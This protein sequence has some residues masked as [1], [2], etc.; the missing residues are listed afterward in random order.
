MK[1]LNLPNECLNCALVLVCDVFQEKKICNI[2][3]HYVIGNY[4]LGLM[5]VIKEIL[6]QYQKFLIYYDYL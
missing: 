6:G 2:Y 5:F 3:Q 4:I 1:L